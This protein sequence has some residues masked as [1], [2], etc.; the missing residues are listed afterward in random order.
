MYTATILLFLSMP[1]VLGSLFSFFIFLLYPI[2]I[3]FRIIYEEKLLE[4]ELIGY[5]DY[6]KKVK[7]RIIPFI[8]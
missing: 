5:K 2:L 3:I 6:K 8:W 7:Y 4:K 1:L